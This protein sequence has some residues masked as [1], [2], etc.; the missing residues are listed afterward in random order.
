[1][2]RKRVVRA[3]IIF[4]IYLERIINKYELTSDFLEDVKK[5]CKLCC[6]YS[7]C[8]LSEEVRKCYE[9][10]SLDLYIFQS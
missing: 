1:M 2:D 7:K 3:S 5:G 4:K 6:K 9:K 10:K 8:Y